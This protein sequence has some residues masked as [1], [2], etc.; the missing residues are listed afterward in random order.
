M[1]IATKIVSLFSILIATALLILTL[2]LTFGISKY[3][4]FFGIFLG[5]YLAYLCWNRPRARTMTTVVSLCAIIVLGSFLY[6]VIPKETVDSNPVNYLAE[7]DDFMAHAREILP[8]TL[9]YEGATNVSYRHMNH[10]MG[11]QYIRIDYSFAAEDFDAQ[12][13]AFA[14]RYLTVK[15]PFTITVSKQERPVY[16]IGIHQDASYWFGYS[17]DRESNT[18]SLIYLYDARLSG[19]SIEEI[20]TDWHFDTYEVA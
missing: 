1:Q 8:Q 9:E 18:I 3:V 14:E 19:I 15:D 11:I 2:M 13:A 12:T 4:A 6:T 10:S 7:D 20:L 5:F 16:P 17:P